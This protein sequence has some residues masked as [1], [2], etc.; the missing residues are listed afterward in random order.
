MGKNKSEERARE[1]TGQQLEYLLLTRDNCREMWEAEARRRGLAIEK[2]KVNQTAVAWV[3][4]KY[5]WSKGD[6]PN[7]DSPE[8]FGKRPWKDGVSRAFSGQILPSKTL[9]YFI[10]AFEMTPKDAEHLRWLHHGDV[11]TE[12]EPTA[13][14]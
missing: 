14:H 7:P 12:D 3:I 2:G 13:H 6:G 4:A 5:V 1:A 8:M 9:E 11:I 10:E